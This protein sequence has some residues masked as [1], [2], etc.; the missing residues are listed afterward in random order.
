VEE[1]V[2]KQD[3]EKLPNGLLNQRDAGNRRWQWSRRRIF[4]Q[5]QSYHCGWGISTL[6]VS[7][8]SAYNRY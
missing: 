3:R 6:L 8:A 1:R 4:C 2:R 7:S 5:H